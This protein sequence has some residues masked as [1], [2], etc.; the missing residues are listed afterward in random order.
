MWALSSE[1]WLLRTKAQQAHVMRFLAD[2]R[3]DCLLSDMSK[4]GFEAGLQPELVDVL[5]CY[6]HSDPAQY[7]LFRAATVVRPAAHTIM[8]RIA[9]LR[10]T[11]LYARLMRSDNSTPILKLL[12]GLA[13]TTGGEYY[14]QCLSVLP[15]RNAKG[16]RPQ[17]TLHL[18]AATAHHTVDGPSTSNALLTSCPAQH[19]APF[20]PEVMPVPASIACVLPVAS[21]TGTASAP[22]VLSGFALPTGAV[23]TP[24]PRKKTAY[25]D[26]TLTP[27]RADRLS[28]APL[29]V[30]A[31]HKANYPSHLRRSRPCQSR[32]C[33][34]DRFGLFHAKNSLQNQATEC[35]RGW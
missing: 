23:Q 8:M 19:V 9:A 16:K 12:C 4:I 35:H 2:A 28:S 20:A 5:T 10:Y 6:N 17:F 22:V 32:F 27:R 13:L 31:V 24:T 25:M 26:A 14:V 30:G 29:V 33:V 15:T 7:R 11:K 34:C 18:P 1:E 21:S 3:L